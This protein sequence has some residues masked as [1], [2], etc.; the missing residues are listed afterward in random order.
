MPL[1]FSLMTSPNQPMNMYTTAAKPGTMA[2]AGPQ[3]L[4]RQMTPSSSV[5]NDAEAMMGHL[6]EWGT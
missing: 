3:S 6:L 5:K 4:S 2:Q 1:L